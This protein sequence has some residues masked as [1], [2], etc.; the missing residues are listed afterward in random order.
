MTN[1]NGKPRVNYSGQQLSFPILRRFQNGL[2]HAGIAYP[3]YEYF[4]Q[5]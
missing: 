1:G 2:E 4:F 3:T 5:Q